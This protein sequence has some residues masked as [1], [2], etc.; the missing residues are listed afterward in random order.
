M[1]GNLSHLINR[2][3][4]DSMYFALTLVLIC[5]ILTPMGQI[6]LKS[7]M[8]QVGEITSVK[9]LFNPGTL[10][11][12][13]TNPYVLGGISLSAVA[14]VLWLGAMSTLDISFM[15]S[16]GSLSFVV[17]A[18]I[19]LV[20]LKEDITLIRWIGIFVVAIGCFLISRTG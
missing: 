6:M 16:L 1:S 11:H 4:G 3:K 17:L 18:I 9:Q 13:F 10:F 7:G 8:S 19:A 20:F 2:M 15:Y 14:L 12:M 5:V